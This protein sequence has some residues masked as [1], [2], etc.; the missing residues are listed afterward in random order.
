[1]DKKDKEKFPPL[2]GVN[3]TYEFSDELYLKVS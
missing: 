2:V 3:E 1:M